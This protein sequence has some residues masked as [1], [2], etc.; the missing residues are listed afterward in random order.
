MKYRLLLMCLCAAALP[1]MATAL[2]PAALSDAEKQMIAR[3]CRDAQRAMQRL[4]TIDP[5]SRVN[6]GNGY[7]NVAKL[8]TAMSSRAAYN[9]YSIPQFAAATNAV[10]SLRQQFSDHYTDY[11]IALQD[12]VE[13]DCST[14]PQ[15]FYRALV[16][17]RAKRAVV[18]DDVSKL[19]AQLDIFSRAMIELQT[20]IEANP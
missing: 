9:S 17:V 7:S 1:T 11:E 4:E 14:K 10:Q 15:S 3:S 5:I 20:L 13:M 8:M 2:D 12:V 16:D 19:D 18:N 6:R